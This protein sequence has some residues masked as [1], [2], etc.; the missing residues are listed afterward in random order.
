M[1][2]LTSLVLWLAIAAICLVAMFYVVRAAVLSALRSHHAEI[3]ERSPVGDASH[4]NA[5]GL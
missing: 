2:L 5:D 4:V 3:A 1:D